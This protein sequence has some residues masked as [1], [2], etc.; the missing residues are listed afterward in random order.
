MNL[1]L[2]REALDIAHDL[3]QEKAREVHVRLEGYRTHAHAAVDADVAKIE[4]AHAELMVIGNQILDLY[5]N[6][7]NS[8][9]LEANAKRYR[10]LRDTGSATWRTFQSQWQM[11][12]DQCDAAIDAEMQRYQYSDRSVAQSEGKHPAPCARF[13]EAQAFNLELKAKDRRIAE[14]EADAKR[15]RHIIANCFVTEAAMQQSKNPSARA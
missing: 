14:L 2:I 3:A 15:Y 1:E 8:G 6:Q 11:S 9:E 4:E 10:W 7:I 13:C 5:M 12:A